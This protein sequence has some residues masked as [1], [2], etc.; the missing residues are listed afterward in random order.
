MR[1]DA[2]VSIVNPARGS[3]V[4]FWITLGIVLR[5]ALA[6]ISIGTN[7]ATTFYR[8]TSEI[9]E[10]GL[11]KTYSADPDF[12]HPPLPALWAVLGRAMSGEHVHRF[13]FL[14]KL[15]PTVADGISIYLLWK[16]YRSF[17]AEKLIEPS[18][19]RLASPPMAAFALLPAAG[20]ALSPDSILVTGF[21]CNTDPCYAM[22]C[23]LSV[24]LIERHA[25]F[26]WGGIALAA[27]INV[28]LIPVLLIPPLLFS[29]RRPREACNF[30]LGLS[31]GII[32]FIPPLL[33]NRV[34]FIH[35]V[36][37]YGSVID[38]WGI[39][40]FLMGRKREFDPSSLA[41]KNTL[42][43]SVF[44]RLLIPIVVL[45]WALVARRLKRW[46]R[47]QICSV[48]FAIFLVITPGFGPQ[49]TAIIGPLLFASAIPSAIAYACASGAFLA[50]G[51]YSFW[52]GKFPIYANY[53]NQ[54]SIGVGIVGLCAWGTLI[55]YL[56][57]TLSKP[58]SIAER[59]D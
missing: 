58:I 35:N 15:A 2:E 27:A 41:G 54:L 21:H 19:H 44:G 24:Y 20:F 45:I 57:R 28:K 5:L 14:F 56:F 33:A 46:N 10:S 1:R 18:A 38:R 8:F 30:L 3:V 34:G 16:I 53:T 47:Y 50:C 43:Y 52:D 32:P 22:L 26:F 31:L 59:R 12:N 42:Y 6:S 29:C 48:T 11:L 4:G 13:T 17:D 9:R 23:L 49:Y 40:F 37:S 7:D 39:L 51:Y 36:V 55:V 25:R